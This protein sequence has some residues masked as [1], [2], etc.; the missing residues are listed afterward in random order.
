MMNYQPQHIQ[1][2]EIVDIQKIKYKYK[3]KINPWAIRWNQKMFRYKNTCYSWTELNTNNNK[4]GSWVRDL[5]GV[6]FKHLFSFFLGLSVTIPSLPP[7]SLSKLGRNTRITR[8]NQHFGVRS[9]IL[10]LCLG[11]FCTFVYVRMYV[12]VCNLSELVCDLLPR[13]LFDGFS[14]RRIARRVS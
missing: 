2:R 12:S 4:I 13:Q 9:P 11:L 14:Y 7:I 5:L 10:L 3:S 1:K 6:Q 8:T